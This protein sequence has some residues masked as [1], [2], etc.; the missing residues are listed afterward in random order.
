MCMK[1]DRVKQ[2]GPSHQVPTGPA[3]TNRITTVMSQNLLQQ[4]AAADAGDDGA[5]QQRADRPQHTLLQSTAAGFESASCAAQLQISAR[6]NVNIASF[7]WQEA[8]QG[9]TLC[10]EALLYKVGI[11]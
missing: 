2:T 1:A 10:Y 5:E 8:I 6:C 3:G 7:V 4:E 11:Y 9:G